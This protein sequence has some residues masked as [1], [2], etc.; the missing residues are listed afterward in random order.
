MD[1]TSIITAAFACIGT[2]AGSLYGIKKSN[3][4][5]EYRMD[6]LETKVDKHNSVVERT[7]RLEEQI[8]TAN[9]RIADLEEASK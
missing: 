1:W 7:Y 2:A 5:I 9:H 3:S 6:K 4:L 8:K